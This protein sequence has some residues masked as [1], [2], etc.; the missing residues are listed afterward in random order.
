M[1][2]LSRA[3][4]NLISNALRYDQTARVVL[5]QED[6]EVIVSVDDEGPGIAANDIDRMMKAFTRGE[7]SRNRSTG[8]AGLGLALVEAITEQHGGRVV[9]QNRT[10]DAGE[11]VGLSAKIALPFNS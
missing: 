4:R 10:D 2:W 1:T 3:I 11:P 5:Y 6:S 7:G 8:G 9:L